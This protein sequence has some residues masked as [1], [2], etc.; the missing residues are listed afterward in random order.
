MS[1]PQTLKK[2]G[3]QICEFCGFRIEDTDQDC[4]ALD[5]GRCR[6]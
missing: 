5:N 3:R 1:R 2:D 4:P 6:P